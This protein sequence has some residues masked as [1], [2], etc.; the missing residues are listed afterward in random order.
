MHLLSAFLHGEHATIDKREIP[1]KSNEI[2]ELKPLLQHLNLCGRTV[3][4]DALHSQHETARFLVE[5][6]G[7]LLRCAHIW[8]TETV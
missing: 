7:W 2:P 3:T 5:D 8:R 1:A 4:A 6:C